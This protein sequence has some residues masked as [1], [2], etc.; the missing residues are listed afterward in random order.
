MAA[1]LFLSTLGA[2]KDFAR[3]ESYFALGSRLMTTTGDWLTPHA[4]DEPVLNKPPLQYWL[5]GISYLTLGAGYATARLPSALAALGVLLVVY[6]LGRKLGDER[7][8]LASC[9]MLAT[10]YLFYSFARTAM[11]DMLLTFCVAAALACFITVLTG[12]RERERVLVMCGYVFT[13]LGFLAKGPIALVLIMLPIVIELLVSR[14]FNALKRLRPLSGLVVMLA[15]AGPYFFLLYLK[16]GSEPL[17]VFFIGENLQRFTGSIYSAS[18]RPL[19]YLVP[20]FFGNFAPWSLLIFPAIYFDWRIARAENPNERRAQRLVYLWLLCPVVFFSFSSFKLDYYL[21]PAMP[22]AALL[23]GRLAAHADELPR[24]ARRTI[25]VFAFAVAGFVIVSLVMQMK[26]TLALSLV[27]RVP[28]LPLVMCAAAFVLVL[29]YIKLGSPRRV[30]FSLAFVIWLALLT[31]GWTYAPAF[32]SFQPVEK[33]AASIPPGARVYTSYGTSSWVNTLAFHL[34]TGQAVT[35]LLS[36]ASGA[37]RVE[38]LRNEP[39]AVVLVN[40]DEYVRLLEAR[41]ALRSLAE[42]ET[43]GH[44]G[45][46]LDALRERRR[47]RLRIV[48]GVR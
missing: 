28:W 39:E 32:S 34:P 43:F 31:T 13:A 2:Y 40:D 45:L 20:A 29:Y 14:D 33:L 5:T 10:S 11:S 12:E 6:L 9:A 23:T 8:G 24:W 16:L 26:I 46:T 36:D 42:G 21:L 41:V 19:W 47:E 7:T 27:V 3:A 22:A 48:Q 15:V 38:V 44:A 17:L 37:R 25:Y 30:L 18:A 1:T 35:S 4:P